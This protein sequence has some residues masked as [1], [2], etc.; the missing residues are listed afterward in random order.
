MRS[1]NA[2]P[3][4]SLLL[5]T[6][7]LFLIAAGIGTNAAWARPAVTHSA[8][9]AHPPAGGRS[10]PAPK[11]A[12][13]KPAPAP[14]TP[15]TTGPG[16]T[17][18]PEAT[19]TTNANDSLVNNDVLNLSDPACGLSG[20]TVEQ[21]S[22]C[23]RTGDPSVPYPL[24]NYQM[25]IHMSTGVTHPINDFF[26]VLESV[27]NVIWMLLLYILK[28]GLTLVSWAFSLSPFTN[29]ATLGTVQNKLEDVYRSLDNGW[30]DAV[31]VAIGGYGVYLAFVRRRQSEAIGHLGASA[32]AILLAIAIIHEPQTFIGKPAGFVNSF[33][34]DA[35]SSANLAAH[36][37][38]GT[39]P[40]SK[41][42]SLT[43]D[44]FDTFATGPFCALETNDVNWCMA[45]PSPLEMEAVQRAVK[46][47]HTYEKQAKAIAADVASR[48]PRNQQQKAYKAV[49]GS[50]TSN[51]AP[52]R[53]ADLFLRYPP[54]STPR[55][56]LYA[57]YS[58]EDLEGKNPIGE[59]I[60]ETLAGD[61]SILKD[62]SKGAIVAVAADVVLNAVKQSWAILKY[63]FHLVTKIPG[64]IAGLASKIFGSGEEKLKALAPNK[65]A[66]QGSSGVV[67]RSLVLVLTILSLIGVLLVLLWL[68]L[69]L[70]SQALLG[71]VLLF[72]T[73][74]MMLAPAFGVSG[75]KAFGGWAKTLL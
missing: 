59:F 54:G 39:V 52:P 63:S 56:T 17:V 30:I 3:I 48:L 34:Q 71:F 24:G 10:K 36:N 41:L 23:L 25:D 74:V 15:V 5:L 8:S 57:L 32:V 11:A 19:S 21:A 16:S 50:L 61:K 75:R 6:V 7:M 46:D 38:S 22:R 4:A 60:H 70:V 73:P 67:Q 1:T 13:T 49:Y 51:A 14:A 27:M 20:M 68:A 65:I 42:A 33:A 55:E 29:A 43:G 9:K 40:S 31:F 58:G 18:V 12:P 35:I 53:R 2:C 64:E 69:H 37:Q 66:I 28:G 62:A 44:L 26:T 47:D 72:A 45:T